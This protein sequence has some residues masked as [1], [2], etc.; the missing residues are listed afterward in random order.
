MELLPLVLE[1]Y[2]RHHYLICSFFKQ[3][4]KCRELNVSIKPGPKRKNEDGTPDKRQRV[5][6]EKKKG[7]PDLKPHKHKKGE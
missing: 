4:D 3:S 2:Q 7:H 6:P 5:T 1:L